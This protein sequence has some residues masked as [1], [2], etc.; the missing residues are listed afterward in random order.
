MD[1]ETFL[2]DVRKQLEEGTPM[3][4]A[5]VIRRAGG[6]YALRIEGDSAMAIGTFIQAVME[7]L[8]MKRED[9]RINFVPK[10][11]VIPQQ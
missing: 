7:H 8:I 6:G 10:I 3:V 1:K 4:A 5:C 9:A 11:N 2:K